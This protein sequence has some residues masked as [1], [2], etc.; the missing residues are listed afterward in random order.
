[1]NAS[2]TNTQPH[3]DIP[4]MHPDQNVWIN[5]QLVSA[6][7][8]S[9]SVFDHGLLYGDG[10]FEGIR[11]YN[12]RILKLVTHLKRLQDGARAIALD[13][14]YT[15]DE[16]AQAVK[17]TA[18]SNGITD[19]YIRL[20]VTRGTGP[21]GLNP[22]LCKRP[23]VFIIATTIKLYDQELYDNGLA[24]VTSGTIRNHPA[25][26]DPRIK[27]LNYLNNILAKI[28]GLNA[29]VQETLMLNHKG[30][31]AECS[32]D[33]IF[34]VNTV[35]DEV[36]I[37]T[38]PPT[39]GILEGITR[40]LVIDLAREAGHT[41]LETEMSRYDL[42]TADEVFLTGT[43]A[44]VIAVTEIDMRKIGTGSPGPITQS[45]VKQF[46]ELVKNAPED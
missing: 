7:Q 31:V 41:V 11:A 42:L 10:V 6:A 39:A 1:M 13:I 2:N 45:L 27:S 22:F 26:L 5:G 4:A 34:I 28:E 25:A 37:K 17:E 36:V 38:P 21:L 46:K 29:N 40:Q 44:E 33:N 23:T 14:P 35:K 15:T 9:V 30:E 24:I 19:G 8:A 43:A 18:Q 12:G 20:V 3:N 32:A 16:L